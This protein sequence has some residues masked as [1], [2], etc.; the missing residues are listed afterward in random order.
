LRTLEKQTQGKRRRMV[1]RVLDAVNIRTAFAQAESGDTRAFEALLESV[2]SSLHEDLS[3]EIIRAIKALGY[4]PNK[5]AVDMLKTVISTRRDHI[6]W[7]AATLALMKIGTAEA[8]DVLL[9]ALVS[10]YE[11][12][13]KYAGRALMKM[14]GE[15]QPR[16]S[17]LADRVTGE[18]HRAVMSVLQSVSMK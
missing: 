11:S 17:K 7:R 8:V 12:L 13:R 2:K 1:A 10:D 15:I 5:R 3:P 4:C 18:K 16:L 9:E 14:E 6:S